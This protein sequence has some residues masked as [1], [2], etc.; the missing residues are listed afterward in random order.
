MVNITIGCFVVNQNNIPV[1]EYEGNQITTISNDALLCEWKIDS[2][3]NMSNCSVKSEPQKYS[4]SV[5]IRFEESF[6]VSNH[7]MNN[8]FHGKY[9][10]INK[11]VEFYEFGHTNKY[12][13]Q[14][15]NNLLQQ[16]NI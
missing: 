13:T 12:E 14:P 7:S 16:P 9:R 5:I 8:N 2:F 3:L 10:I 15:G 6:K 11:E 4:A 1:C